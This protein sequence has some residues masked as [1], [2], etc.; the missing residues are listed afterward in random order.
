MVGS[1]AVIGMGP[2]PPTIQKYNLNAKD[3][4]GVA[5]LDSSMQTLQNAKVQQ[6]ET[7]TVMSF[8]TLLDW[9][10]GKLSLS[11]SSNNQLIYAYGT[12]NALLRIGWSNKIKLNIKFYASQYYWVRLFA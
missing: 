12:S 9:N 10:N 1:V 8:E 4:A 11:P 5:A 7:A 2:G 6:S 3:T